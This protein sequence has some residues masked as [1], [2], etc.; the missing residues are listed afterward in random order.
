MGTTIL[1]ALIF[2]ILG[3]FGNYLANWT[4]V[5]LAQKYRKWGDDRAQKKA[6]KSIRNSRRRIEKL[7]KKIKTITGYIQNPASLNVFAF[8]KIA[9]GMYF[10]FGAFFFSFFML[11]INSSFFAVLPIPE[12]IISLITP[13][14]ELFSLLGF[15]VAI[16]YAKNML[17]MLDSISDYPKIEPSIRQQIS[18]LQEVIKGMEQKGPEIQQ[19]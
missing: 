5:P 11:L 4:S 3:L 15:A 9:G 17:D 14:V 18:D 1:V 19:K 2:F 16:I 12:K 8:G 7:E 10:I 6:S 13:I